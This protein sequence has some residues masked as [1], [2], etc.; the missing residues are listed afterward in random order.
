MVA[1]SRNQKTHKK[2]IRPGISIYKTGRSI[3]WQARIWVAGERRYKVKSTKETSRL[4]AEEVAEEIYFNLK[5]SHFVDAIPRDRLFNFYADKL[6]L[7][8]RRMDGSVRSRRFSKDDEWILNR[9]D[10]GLI[11]YFGS[12]DV[13][14][15]TTPAIREYLNF[16]DDRREKPLAAS[17]KNR[18]LNVIRK[19]L[20]LAYEHQ[21]ISHIP[22]SPKIPI[23]DNPRPT[24]TRDEYLKLLAVTRKAAGEDVMVRG[25][26]LTH[27]IYY[28]I[29]F[30]AHSYLRPTESEIF[31][32]RHRDVEIA[33]NPTRL[34]MAVYGKTSFKRRETTQYGVGFYKKMKELHPDYKPE[35]FIFFP[36]YSNRRT[37]IRAVNRQFNYLLE[38]A[39]LKIANNGQ[40]ITPYALR[41]YALQT[42]LRKSG[43]RVNLY[44]LAQNAG[45]SIDQLERFYLNG[46]EMSPERSKALQYRHDK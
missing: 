16:L 20:N 5:Q 37:A 23:Q 21:I 11:D 3:F 32:L 4:L 34:I 6:I 39:E 8:Q 25:V 22:I 35:D 15:I 29:V 10:D 7:D 46:M 30:M 17:T 36:N 9:K 38:R 31:A 28:F 24:F 33:K 13:A 44:D 2:T 19:V 1:K 12:M 27:E 42:R 40:K 18:H 45:T 43:G 14:K 41:H 26:K